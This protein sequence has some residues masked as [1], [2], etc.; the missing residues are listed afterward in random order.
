MTG[1][2]LMKEWVS[3][4]KLVYDQRENPI[5]IYSCLLFYYFFLCSPRILSYEANDIHHSIR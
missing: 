1:K 4:L 2:L 5:V 3:E